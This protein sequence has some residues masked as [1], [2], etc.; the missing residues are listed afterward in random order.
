MSIIKIDVTHAG[1]GMEFKELAFPSDTT[2]GALKDK[3]YPRTGTEPQHMALSLD[4]LALDDEA[5]TLEALGLTTGSIVTLT[6]TNEASMSN[7][8]NVGASKVEK[9]EAKSGDAGFAKFRKKAVKKRAEATDDTDRLEAEALRVGM[10][11]KSKKTGKTGY[12]RFLGPIEPLPK[13]F[14]CGVELDDASGRN[15]GEVKGV[16][17]FTCDANRGAVLRPSGVTPIE[18]ESEEAMESAGGKSNAVDDRSD[19]L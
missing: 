1:L 7:N 13:G 16:R 14:W 11:V 2:L 4:G 10:R 17:L 15:D 6:D 9:Y 3:L 8:L 12:L 18:E 19:E 5:A